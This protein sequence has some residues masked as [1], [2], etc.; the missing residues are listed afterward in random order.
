[1]YKTSGSAMQCSYIYRPMQ[2]G[3]IF[4]L[5]DIYDMHVGLYCWQSAGIYVSS[6]YHYCACK[7]RRYK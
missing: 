1:M 6:K 5:Y 3:E 4:S 2:G 7:Y